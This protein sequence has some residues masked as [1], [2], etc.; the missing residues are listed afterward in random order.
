MPPHDHFEQFDPLAMARRDGPQDGIGGPAQRG[1]KPQRQAGMVVPVAVVGM[2][3][4]MVVDPC[5]GK[6][7]DFVGSDPF[8][9]DA[10]SNPPQSDDRP[11]SL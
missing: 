1:E 5:D 7:V 8:Q 9:Q 10:A 3:I 6:N 2:S 11:R 4:A